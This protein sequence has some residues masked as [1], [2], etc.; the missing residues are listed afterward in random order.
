VSLADDGSGTAVGNAQTTA[1]IT[2]ATGGALDGSVVLTQATEHVALATS[3]TVATFTDSDTTDTAGGFTA[4][5][6]WGDG[7]TTNGTVTGSNGSFSVTGGHTYGDE[8]SDPVGVTITRT[9]DSSQITPTGSVTVAEN[10][11]LSGTAATFGAN[12]NFVINGTVVT[13]TDTDATTAASDLAATINWGDGTTTAGTVTGANGSFSVSGQHVYAAPGTDNISVTLAD[14]A[15]GTASKTVNT[16]VTPGVLLGDVNGNGVTDPGET[17]LFVPEV[18]AQ[19]LINHASST[20]LRVSVMTQ[21]LDA[22]IRIDQG[23][24]DPGSLTPGQ[25]LITGVVDW[26]RGLAPFTSSLS[27]NVDLNHDGTLESGPTNAGNEYNTTSQAFTS[28]IVTA[29]TSAG[30]VGQLIKAVSAFNMDQLVT[31]MAG[32]KVGWTVAAPRAVR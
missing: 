4:S 28:P 17:T 25:D 18:A 11:V 23:E 19:Q 9:S 2:N 21:A 15:P 6:N 12:T 22:Q 16:S 10:D 32:T 5:I 27:G 29:N 24:A 13:F 1:N 7:I 20:D 30:S 3:T 14:D 8:G 31:F 26:L